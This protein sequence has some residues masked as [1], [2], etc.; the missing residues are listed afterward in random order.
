MAASA[1]NLRFLRALI[2]VVF[3]V[4]ALASSWAFGQASGV[5]PVDA[6][7]STSTFLVHGF[8]TLGAVSNRSDVLNFRRDMGQPFDLGSQP[9]YTPDTRVG[10]QLNYQ[11]TPSL[12]LVGQWVL[13]SAAEGAK[14]IDRV[15]WAFV[16][17][18]LTP[19]LRVRLGRTGV[20]VFLMA[21]VRNVGYAYPW[22]RPNTEFYGWVP[23]FS[24][25]GVDIEQRFNLGDWTWRAKLAAGSTNSVF[26]TAPGWPN[27]DL[28]VRDA[29]TF[30][31]S[32]DAPPWSAKL[33]YLTFRIATE[34]PASDL[35]TGLQALQNPMFGPVAQEAAELD[36]NSR[37]LGAKSRYWALGLAYDQSP[38]WAQAEFAYVSSPA[39]AMVQGRRA[40]A[41]V[42]YRI[43]P[44]LL[45]VTKSKADSSTGAQSNPNWFAPMAP[46]VGP[47]VAAQM[48]AVG[49]GAAALINGTRIDQSTFAVGLRW[50]VSENFAL[51]AQVDDV[52]VRANG[53]SLWTVK[54]DGLGDQRVKIWTL[55]LDFVF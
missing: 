33:S 23:V 45:H 28:Q 50:D 40:Y 35:H 2:R 24:V 12:E 16:G 38:W 14:P 31:L 47:V 36:M 4:L 15:E 49:S 7:K 46:V 44:V 25:D 30:V 32:A 1:A 18:R 29:Y 54:Q 26:P 43:G 10:L 48:Q 41:S 5:G 8:G 20:D 13:R 39:V 42:G 22:V 52:L 9:R 55:T 19:D 51:K 21:D 34:Y 37:V 6:D 17:Y 3:C 53:Q 11:P 27:Y